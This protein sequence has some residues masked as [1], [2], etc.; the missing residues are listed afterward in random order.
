MLEEG[1]PHLARRCQQ[2]AV[3]HPKVQGLLPGAATGPVHNSRAR[4]PAKPLWRATA[5]P[6]IQNRGW[7]PFTSIGKP[8]KRQIPPPRHI[9]TPRRPPKQIRKSSLERLVSSTHE[10]IRFKTVLADSAEHTWRRQT[11]SVP[12]A[13]FQARTC[14]SRRRCERAVWLKLRSG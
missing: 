3:A 4:G 13:A 2:A 6:A 11:S 8:Q 7:R 10:R 1:Q 14:T 5:S 9:S 12:A